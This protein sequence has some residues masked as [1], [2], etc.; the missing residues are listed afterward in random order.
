M[1]ALVVSDVHGRTENLEKIIKLIHNK[2][3]ELILLL[4]DLTNFGG[5]EEAAQALKPLQGFAILA[6]AGNLD[7]ADVANCL[8]E[9][10]ISLH[11]KKKRIG[12]WTFAGFGGGLLGDP[13]RF[14]FGEGEIRESLLRLAE[15]EKNL[16]LLTHLPPLGTRLD[17]AGS[18]THVGSKA[19][20]QVVEE[21]QPVLHLCGHVHEAFGEQRIGKTTSINIGAVKEGKALL[22]F[23]GDEPK[24]ERVQL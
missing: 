12:K 15:G 6:I 17:L 22:L 3:V 23:L 10:G 8:E 14:L 19:V 13:G 4:G 24:W 21:K 20:K 5:K 1:L 2:G 9:R 18:G 7:T 16:V 11:G